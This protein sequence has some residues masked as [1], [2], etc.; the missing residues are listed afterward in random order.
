MF[1]AKNIVSSVLLCAQ[2]F[3]VGTLYNKYFP[4]NF[5]V[6]IF[7]HIYLTKFMYGL[8]SIKV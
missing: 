4:Y 2:M 8:S 7:L 3:L 1:L 6:K 5:I